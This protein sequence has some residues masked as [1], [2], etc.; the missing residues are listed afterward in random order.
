M[1][2]IGDRVGVD[3]GPESERGKDGDLVRGVEAAD[4]E[5]RVGFGVAEALRLG[6]ARRERTC[7][8]VSIRERM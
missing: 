1:P 8:R 4:V 3:L 6:E 2:S 7:P 5:G